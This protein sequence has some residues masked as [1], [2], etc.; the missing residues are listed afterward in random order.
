MKSKLHNRS[1][2]V[3]V[4]YRDGVHHSEYDGLIGIVM[5]VE[6]FGKDYGCWVMFPNAS[7]LYDRTRWHWIENDHLRAI[8]EA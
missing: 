8:R 3:E 6:H 5:E 2:L 1:D 4:T 7:D